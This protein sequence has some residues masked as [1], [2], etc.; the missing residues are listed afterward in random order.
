MRMRR[1]RRKS[2]LKQIE[3]P[4][5]NRKMSEKEDVLAF[6]RTCTDMI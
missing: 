6:F 5:R 1:R 4:E 3:E 2:K